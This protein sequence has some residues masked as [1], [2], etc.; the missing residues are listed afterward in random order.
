MMVDQKSISKLQEQLKNCVVP[1]VGKKPIGKYI[2]IPVISELECS[3]RFTTDGTSINTAII[4]VNGNAVPVCKAHGRKQAAS[5]RRKAKEL[6]RALIANE[7]QKYDSKWSGCTMSVNDMC[8]NCPECVL[9]GS[10]ASEGSISITSRVMYDEA[11]TIRSPNAIVKNIFQGAPGDDYTKEPSS[12]IFEPD[13]LV[14]GTL[15]PR[16][17]TLKD[18]TF[19]EVLFML[20]VIDRNSRYGATSSRFGKVRNHILGV[21]AGTREGPSSLELTKGILEKLANPEQKPTIEE[22]ESVMLSDTLDINQVKKFA[23]ETYKK[24]SKQYRI[25][26]DIEVTTVEV[27]NI[28]EELTDDIVKSTLVK[29][30]EKTRSFLS[31]DNGSKGTALKKPPTKKE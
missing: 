22:I 17:I 9:F 31:K 20:N 14:E 26:Y 24:L 29:Q 13:F 16:I 4:Q 6:Q 8:Q 12:S 3:G 1:I 18:V 27:T 23:L 5:E 15:F 11:F 21:Y 28:L 25:P 19:E 7:M 2:S 10:A 30:I